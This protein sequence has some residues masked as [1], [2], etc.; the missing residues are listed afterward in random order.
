M[1]EACEHRFCHFKDTGCLL[2]Y[3][4]SYNTKN[5]QRLYDSKIKFFDKVKST[6]QQ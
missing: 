2:I 1:I 5:P 6:H 4:Y 3:H